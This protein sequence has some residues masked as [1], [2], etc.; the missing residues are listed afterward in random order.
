MWLMILIERSL[1]LRLILVFP[2]ARVIRVL[3]RIALERGYPRKI[4]SD[5]GPEFISISFADW[6]EDHGVI[7][8]FIV[9]WKPTQNSFIE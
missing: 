8:D 6:S 2:A 9:P 7:L 1:P 5:N 3:G 4:R